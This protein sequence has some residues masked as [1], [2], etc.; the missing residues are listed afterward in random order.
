MPNTSGLWRSKLGRR[1]PFL[2]TAPLP[3]AA[4]FYCIYVP[5]VGLHGIPLF[6][7]FTFF[8]VLF[9]QFLTVYQVPHLALGAELST[10]YRERSVV[11]SYNAIFAVIGGA[12]TYFYGWTW[13]KHV[14]GGTTVRAGYPGLAAGVAVFAAVVI[15]ASAYFTR[16]QIPRLAK[17]S[18]RSEAS[19]RP[20][21]R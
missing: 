10:D 9:R 21:R 1:H 5:P 13:F 3:L 16:D 6:V 2:Y 7:W 12:S 18:A 14:P 8:T 11:M 20:R 17:P 4:S 19:L 15:F